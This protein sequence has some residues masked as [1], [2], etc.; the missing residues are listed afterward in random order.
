MKKSSIFLLFGLI[1]L[2]A[3]ALFTSCQNVPGL[4]TP[5]AYTRF[6]TTGSQ[7]IFYDSAMYG[8]K[9]ITVYYDSAEDP[10]ITFDFDRTL[11]ADFDSFDYVYILVDCKNRPIEMR[12]TV[13]KTFGDYSPTKHFYLNGSMLNG[14]ETYDC[15]YFIT[16]TFSNVELVRTNTNNTLHEDKVN[17]LEYK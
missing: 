12:A 13:Y 3:F 17:V 14:T 2:S 4:V 9:D 16:Y 5:V 15:E 10:F 1:A 11:G 8:S 7:K 6:E